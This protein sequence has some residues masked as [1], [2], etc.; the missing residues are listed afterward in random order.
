[1]ADAAMAKATENAR[2][3]IEQGFEAKT[4]QPPFS[5]IYS[6]RP[7]DELLGTWELHRDE[8]NLDE[9]RTQHILR[10]TDR[11]RDSK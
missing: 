10:Y 1:M 5:F 4:P 2:Q 11:T 8:K 6:G 7:S 3:W 9:G